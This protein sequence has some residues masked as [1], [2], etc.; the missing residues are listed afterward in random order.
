[1]SMNRTAKARGFISF[2]ILMLPDPIKN[3]VDQ[4]EWDVIPRAEFFLPLPE[5]GLLVNAFF[6]DLAL[7]EAHLLDHRPRAPV[8]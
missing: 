4:I 5:E 7:D 2:S 8:R 3:F 6:L 1:M